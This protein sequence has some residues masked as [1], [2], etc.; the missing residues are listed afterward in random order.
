M[1]RVELR[2][3]FAGRIE[4]FRL[5]EFDLDVHIKRLS[6]LARAKLGDRYKSLTSGEDAKAAENAVIEVQCR[7]VAEGLV[8]EHGTRI[9]RDDELSAIADE[10]PATALDQLSA[11]ILAISGLGISP[12]ITVK[13]LNPTTSV[14][15][16]SV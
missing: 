7:V 8:D 15:S 6:A 13:N 3:K 16:A 2:A 12:E 9:Y 10:F 5:D 11:R 4:P 14:D 1:D